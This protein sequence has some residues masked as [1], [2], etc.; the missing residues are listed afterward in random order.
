MASSICDEF[1]ADNDVFKFYSDMI[2]ALQLLCCHEVAILKREAGTVAESNGSSSQRLPNFGGRGAGRGLA[3]SGP[4]SSGGPGGRG[5]R[6][7]GGASFAVPT[8]SNIFRG[9]PTTAGPGMAPMKPFPAHRQDLDLASV[10]SDD[11]ASSSSGNPVVLLKNNLKMQETAVK[12]LSQVTTQYCT[13]GKSKRKTN[14]RCVSW[15]EW[16]QK[17]AF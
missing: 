8:Q 13:S 4:S 16:L 5:G 11:K 17:V 9:K 2:I 3:V 10:S 6:V 14:G 12:W 15:L 1:G 7:G